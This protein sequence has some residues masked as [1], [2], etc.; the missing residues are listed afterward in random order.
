MNPS[1]RHPWHRQLHPF[2]LYGARESRE[3]DRATIENFGIPGE[4]L[5]EIAGTRAA[6]WIQQYESPNAQGIILA[7][8]GNNGGDAYV[9]ARLLHE[10]GIQVQV[11]SLV[12][13]SSLTGDARLNAQRWL[14]IDGEIT[15]LLGEEIEK[16]EAHLGKIKVEG[17]TQSFNKT[18][19]SHF[20]KALA[21]ADFIVDGLLGIGI[22]GPVSTS[23]EK[24]INL[25]NKATNVSIIHKYALDIPSGLHPDTGR[26]LGSAFSADFTLCF[27]GIK[28]GYFLEDGPTFCGQ[29]IRCELPIPSS[30]KQAHQFIIDEDWVQRVQGL[31]ASTR[32]NR[33]HKYSQGVI[34]IISGAAGMTGATIYAAKSARAQGAGAVQ[35][36]CPRGLMNLYDYHVPEMVKVG[37]GS[38]TDTQLGYDH[39]PEI[40]S[41][42]SKKD[43]LCVVGPGLGRTEQAMML[44]QCL[45]EQ[46]KGS[47]LLDADSLYALSPSILQK[48]PREQKLVMSP[49]KGE[50]NHLLSVLFPDHK[51]ELSSE[52]ER[53]EWAEYMAKKFGSWI[54]SKGLP[55][56][57][58]SPEGFSYWT[59]Y[60]TTLFNRTGFCDVL[61][62]AMAA[63][64]L[65]TS[66]V[67]MALVKACLQN[68][69]QAHEILSIKAHLSPDDLV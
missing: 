32:E 45:I 50:F 35:I 8:K 25:V 22:N 9:V 2:G 3:L 64:M 5:M 33:T 58:C 12:Q 6:D 10:Y 62:G 47:L 43:G 17:V 65:E 34:Y 52:A 1:S 68:L 28:P 37:I 31:D 54:V 42:L 46:F 49:H 38:E 57:I 40:L 27:G 14:S 26:C 23:H 61:S 56:A 16:K 41:A 30:Y 53:I 11:F 55:T 44:T 69:E 4:S 13:V 29:I 21:T 36:I 48:R 66:S 67:D 15:V 18:A 39:T 20:S 51:Q 7:G 60:D 63:M 24:I 19:L 59:Q